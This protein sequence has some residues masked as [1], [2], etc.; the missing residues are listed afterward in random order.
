MTRLKTRKVP[1][2][3]SDHPFP[4]VLVC[5]TFG[6]IISFAAVWISGPGDGGLTEWQPCDK[7]HR[8]NPS[9]NP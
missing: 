3:S 5:S 7:C 8:G 1:Q 2:L 6:T 4:Y 9:S